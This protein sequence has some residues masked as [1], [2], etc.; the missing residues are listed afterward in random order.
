MVAGDL[1][2]KLK[3]AVDGGVL[4]AKR[5]MNQ[6]LQQLS[7]NLQTTRPVGKPVVF[8]VELTN[9]CPMTCTMCP[10]THSMQRSIGHMSPAIFNRIL[11]EA[12]GSTS[13]FY[14]HHFGDSLLHPDLGYFIGEATRR[15]IRGYLS[16]NPVLL[17]KQRIEAIVDN[18]LHEIV[19]SLDGV[20]PETAEAVRGKAAHNVKMAERR[21]RELVKYRDSVQSPFPRIVL[22]IVRQKQNMHEVGEWVRRWKDAAGIDR[23]KVKS[24]VTW[25]GGED[26]INDLRVAPAAPERVVVCEKPWTSVTILW[27]GTVVP[28]NFDHDALYPLGNI[29]QQTLQEIWRSERMTALRCHHRDGDLDAIDLCRGCIDKEGYPVRK[30]YYP[31]N[32]FQQS[33]TPMSYEFAPGE[34]GNGG[35]REGQRRRGRAVVTRAFDTP[36]KDRP[37]GHRVTRGSQKARRSRVDINPF[38]D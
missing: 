16:A 13:R 20:T 17:T 21:V 30:V 25:S 18:G 23:V 26:L 28:C 34:P 36:Y 32:R 38:E 33:V 29:G 7:Y 4:A 6:E 22:Q 19:L 9:D 31:L 12:A 1:G 10:R 3:G 8:Q 14:L 5:R 27:D 35:G 2:Q 11:A 15:N 24:Y 37:L